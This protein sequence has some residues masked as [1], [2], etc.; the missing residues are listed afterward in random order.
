MPKRVSYMTEF[1]AL[2]AGDEELN[3][4]K[5]QVKMHWKR[6]FTYA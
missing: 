6:D 1:I 2:C 4:M 3:S 5:M